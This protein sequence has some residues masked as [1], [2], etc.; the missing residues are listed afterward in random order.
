M[1]KRLARWWV[2]VSSFL[3]AVMLA[4]LAG[5]TLGSATRAMMDYT[6][7][8]YRCVKYCEPGGEPCET[9]DS[10][11]PIDGWD[12]TEINPVNFMTGANFYSK[13]DL[14]TSGLSRFKLTRM[15]LQDATWSDHSLGPC[16]RIGWLYRL[17][18]NAQQ[19]WVIGGSHPIVSFTDNGGGSY[20]PDFDYVQTLTA[21]AA[22]HL[23]I[24]TDAV[25]KRWVF[26]D[27]SGT[28]NPERRGRLKEF[29]DRAGNITTTVYG[30][31]GVTLDKL[32]EIQQ[33]D[34][35]PAI[36]H[37]FTFSYN[38]SGASI[39]LLASVT[40][41]QT[42]SAVTTTVRVSN[43][44]Y[45]TTGGPN[46]PAGTLQRVQLTDGTNVLETTYYRYDAADV[47]GFVPLRYVVHPHAYDRLVAALGSEAAVDAASDAT[48]APYADFFFQYDAQRRVIQETVQGTGCG[49]G[50]AG[51]R[52][53]FQYSY[54][55]ATHLQPDGPN[56]W[57]NKCTVTE[58]DGNQ[59]I[60]YTNAA[61]QTMLS[62]YKDVLTG[63][64]W[65][66]YFVFNSDSSLAS[67]A[68]PS[69]VTGH[70]ESLAGL[71]T[72]AH[73]PD[74]AG[75]WRLYEYYATTNL[76]AGAV[77][78]Y[79][80]A[81]K[82]RQGELGAPILTDSYT[83]TSR[84]GATST[85]YPVASHTRYRN[86][87]GTGGATL[88]LGYTWQG[89]TTQI[90]Q[91]SRTYPIVPTLQNGSGAATS[92]TIQL[93]AFGRVTWTKDEDGF[94][95]AAE[96]DPLSGAATKRIVDVNTATV[97]N[98]PA[99][100]VTPAGG[101]LHLTTVLQV[102]R[103]GRETQSTDP[104]GRI[105]YTVY[106][107]V[108][109]EVRVY[110]GWNVST[111]LPTGP[112]LLE[113][114]D[115]AGNYRE[116][117][118]MSATPAVVG[119]VPTGTEA[120]GGLQSLSR[121]FL[122][123]GLRVIQKDSYFNL[124]GLTYSTSASLGV[125]GTHFYRALVNYDAKGRRDRSQDWTGTITRTAYDTQS[126]VSSVWVGTDDTPV[127]GDWSPSNTSGTN[128][129]KTLVN[130]YD[131]G[132]VG[133]GTL[134]KR[135]D[136]TSAVTSLDTSY[137][138]DFR[139]REIGRRGPDLVA[140]K[141][142]IDN[143]DRQTVEEIYADANSDFSIGA[144]ELRKKAESRFDEKGQVY[145]SVTHF[146]DPATGTIGNRLTTNNWFNGRGM[147]IK[148]R[149]PNGLF[150]KSAY[151]G[152]GRTKSLFVSFD[153]AET[154]YADASVVTGDTVID[155]TVI[156]LDADGETI[157]QTRYQRT[158]TT[159]KLGDLSVSWAAGQSRRTFLAHWFDIAGRQ[160]DRADYGDNSGTNLSRPATAPLPN[161]SDNY[162]VTHWAY[163]AAGRNSSITDNKAR[164]KEKTYD[165]LGRV[166]QTVENRADG[167]AGETELDTD[168]TTKQVYDSVGRLSQII[169]LNPK[170]S[171][172]GVEQQV[173]QYVYGT[174]VNQATPEVYRNDTL[175]ARID[176]D[177][178]DVY[179]P[180]APAGSQLSN[181]SDAT[182]DRTE[183]AVDYAERRK[184]VTDPRGVV[185]TW[186]YDSVG[187]VTLDAVTTLPGTVDG[188]VRAVRIGYDD[189]SRLV[190]TASTSD[191]A[192]LVTLNEVSY[193]YDGWGG[194]VKIEQAH[195][196][197]VGTGAGIPDV[198]VGFAD[199][200]S[201][202]EAK[203]V[204]KVSMTHPSGRVVYYTY[205]ASGVGDRLDR[206]DAIAN[207]SAGTSIFAQYT[208]LGQDVIGRIDHPLVTTG[209]RRE[210]DTGGNPT[211]IDR[212]GRVLDERWKRSGATFNY[213][214]FQ[215]TYDRTDNRL[216]RDVTPNNPPS[217]R[218]E[219]YTYDGLDR[220]TKMNRGNLASGQITDANALFSQVWTAMES[221]GNWRTF[222]EDTNGG[223]A[224][225]ATTQARTH[226]LANEVS[227]VTG[228][229][230]V[231][232][233]AAHDAGGNQTSGPQSGNEGVR[234]HYT[235]DAWNRLMK[236]Q[237]DAGG[238]PGAT[239][240]EYQFDGLGQRI[241]KLLPN[242]ANW[243][244]TDY[245]FSP[246]WQVVEERSAT[247]VV[248]K[249]T[250][251][252]VP[253]FEWVW[254][255]RH[256]DAVVLRDE[257]KNGDATCTGAGDER[258]FFT[259]DANFNTTALISTA[260]AIVERYSY[261]PYGKTTV[262]SGTWTAQS[263]TIY[264]NEVGFG[265]YRLDPETSLYYARHRFYH[266]TL[267]RWIQRDPVGFGDSK[268]L[269]QYVRSMPT[270]SFDPDGKVQT[271]KAND[272]A[273]GPKAGKCGRYDWY[274]VWELTEESKDSSVI[275]Q[276]VWIYSRVDSCTT[277]G[278]PDIEDHYWEAWEV[279]PEQKTPTEPGTVGK[280]QWNDN[281][282][283][284]D[285]NCCTKGENRH[286]GQAY[287]Y[288]GVT[289]D[290]L[291]AL[292]WKAEPISGGLPLTRKDPTKNPPNLDP[293]KGA[294]PV[295][296]WIRGEWNCCD[297]DKNQ[298]D[299]KD[300]PEGPGKG[301]KWYNDTKIKTGKANAPF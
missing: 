21:D 3:V 152:A 49:C 215:Y 111:N 14:G 272:V 63:N 301:E 239:I 84:S 205:P 65:R 119:G 169:A 225:G 160:T 51:S 74:N 73:L 100:W 131:G 248:G 249:T 238:V 114:E 236:V 299:P 188:S 89:T 95:H 1:S 42:V 161:T 6:G 31:S 223:A 127:S 165:A 16:W 252:T 166:L 101:G 262:L 153:D 200:A 58:P 178:D 251:A 2:P 82:I 167:V 137:Q 151:D 243:D 285:R 209:L 125:L 94:I 284:K 36:L 273:G 189:L 145:Q 269:Y 201:G 4:I 129:V 83:F 186:S 22:N 120:I 244:R 92:A 139:S 286:K 229:A 245:Y 123:P 12:C 19:I 212:F 121:D 7:K 18:P 70:D 234:L 183:Y 144:T 96:F 158:S 23:L 198:Q 34:T 5:P 109:H 41:A 162:R 113:R 106:K 77:A 142:T 8:R 85:I 264:R 295:D 190:S 253:K 67:I 194:R 48:I 46:G 80:S 32:L 208:Y 182:Y 176:P 203:F 282:W 267:G 62:I 174:T 39:G 76:P 81:A 300:C 255:L 266:P 276:E 97:A 214:R 47:T 98:E 260:G 216:T 103:L 11:T 259:Q 136:F 250:V 71:V 237:A 147:V 117:L 163:D 210:R 175:I 218:D 275:V 230:P 228:N 154:L 191:T 54:A 221:L 289:L 130:E 138:Y 64:Q 173:T 99:G 50:S 296:R 104:L 61:G 13:K 231:W 211:E 240:A 242:G 170:G 88:T 256:V 68:N 40:Y 222:V 294:G 141:R 112:T 107:D 25:G 219:A 118:S 28:W 9:K 241:V 172:L 72:S 278:K 287:Y 298:K 157:Q 122:D 185:R 24:L 281:F 27:L 265:G 10:D 195:T 37:R 232:I 91:R 66:Q 292:G 293:K 291:K 164:I 43:Y 217:G 55:V 274:I 115:H 60:V 197:S 150:N 38:L 290:S 93:N 261:T 87:D 108:D 105:T 30:T 254:D 207:D 57:S 53:V 180:G 171:G 226:N 263:S 35:N 33:T 181:G 279:P 126:R 233:T 268:N 184:T 270:V 146:V 247:N 110:P 204:R 134:T 168:R 132:G 29:D 44:S 156:L 143:L 26:Y 246:D 148:T 128:L 192:G 52:G 149:D 75:Y 257:N 206:I 271:L 17:I 124:V 193:A 297:D 288:E 56:V 116:Q 45:Y 133:D 90:L 140:V 199:G 187:R 179:N 79:V 277:K 102:D 258:L 69:A 235:Y 202:G 155:Q 280:E 78:K 177:S 220:L 213:D 86:T 15:Y 227:A 224:G 59:R 283:H 196:G 135:S 159:T 20:T